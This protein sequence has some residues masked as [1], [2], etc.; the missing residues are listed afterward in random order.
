MSSGDM[1]ES[2]LL[3]FAADDAGKTYIESH[4]QRYREMIR[5]IPV[6]R[7]LA[8][9]DVGTF[10]PLAALLRRT[11]PHAYTLH[12]HWGEY[13]Q[14]EVVAQGE[15]FL[16]HGFDVEKETFPFPD[17]SF[18][19]V[20]CA[21]VLEHLGLDPMFMLAEINRVLRPDGRLLLST[22][23]VISARNLTKMYLGYS[24]CLYASFTLTSDR[25]N[26]EYA[27]GEVAAMLRCAGFEV[28]SLHTCDV[29]TLPPLASF[30]SRLAQL[31]VNAL[32]RLGRQSR[33]R[34]DAL[35]AL[36]RKVEPVR[37]RYPAQFYDLPT[38]RV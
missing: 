10:I 8:V 33:L 14:K 20:L 15:S 6:D 35:F 36:A 19:L 24:P 23:N 5:L 2:E 7:P 37:D 4:L 3:R 30:R 21:E 12:G 1:V 22:P 25:H 16:L 26:R 18:D 11:T 9:L 34:G 38:E 31:M 28:D 32:L 29:Y 13:G 27:P 17:A